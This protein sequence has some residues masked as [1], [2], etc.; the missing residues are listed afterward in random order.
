M[1][2]TEPVECVDIGKGAKKSRKK[3]D[4]FSPWESW[5][6]QVPQMK[7][8]VRLAWV[9]KYLFTRGFETC[10][11]SKKGCDKMKTM[12]I[13]LTTSPLA[14]GSSPLVPAKKKASGPSPS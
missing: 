10:M 6:A 2:A 12:I 8:L 7:V 11:P 4:L 5:D 14:E 9:R 13:F 1:V 3:S